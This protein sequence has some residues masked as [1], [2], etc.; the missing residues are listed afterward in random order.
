MVVEA[1]HRHHESHGHHFQVKVELVV[2]GKT[3]MVSHDPPE[4]RSSADPYTAV[5]QAFGV[6]RRQLEEYVHI[7]RNEVKRHANQ[8]VTPRGR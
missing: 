1:A 8:P 7:Q 3:L 5:S 4:Q 2:P 6:M